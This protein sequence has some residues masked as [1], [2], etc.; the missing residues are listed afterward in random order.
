MSITIKTKQVL[1]K[2]VRKI[3]II[4]INCLGKDKLPTKY[5]EEDHFYLESGNLY[6]YEA[7]DV[8][9]DWWMEPGEKLNPEIFFKRK[10]VI[11]NCGKRLRKI[12]K[13]IKKDNQTWVKEI[14]Y[15]I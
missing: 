8:I 2:G 7:D 9:H 10:T 12:N 1:E 15:T 4:E 11:E 5:M 13:E 3:K 6:F 14:T